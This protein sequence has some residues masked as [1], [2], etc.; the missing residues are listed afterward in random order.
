MN[1]TEKKITKFLTKKTASTLRQIFL[2]IQQL[3]VQL[4]IF[5]FLFFY[6][7]KNNPQ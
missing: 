1:A 5:H 7:K 3:N 4:T 6:K 2:Q